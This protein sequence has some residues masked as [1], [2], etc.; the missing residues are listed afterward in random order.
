MPK[1]AT[2]LEVALGQYLETGIRPIAL[3]HYESESEG[4]EDD[5][6]E[7]AVVPDRNRSYLDDLWISDITNS[8]L[9]AT[10]QPGE[11]LNR[12]F[13]FINLHPRDVITSNHLA[14]TPVP[15]E[16]GFDDSYRAYMNRDNA[17]IVRQYLD[18]LTSDFVVD[19]TRAPLC[20]PET[21]TT[22]MDNASYGGYPLIAGWARVGEI[23]A[24]DFDKPLTISGKYQIGIY[25][26][27]NGSGHMESADPTP[28]QMQLN[29]RDLIV[30][31][32]MGWTPDGTFGFVPRYYRLELATSKELACA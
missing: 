7:I 6:V 16:L 8:R 28:F 19:S 21:A 29:R 31:S 2:H 22:I 9:G 32:T 30:C 26:S 15:Q 27:A 25:N 20:S 24:L 14:M 1:Q 10:L 11:N 18:L 12:F 23:L 3:R 13:R 5:M 4:R 17:N